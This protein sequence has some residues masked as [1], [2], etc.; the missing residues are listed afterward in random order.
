MGEVCHKQ[1]ICT[2][3]YQKRRLRVYFCNL[4]CGIFGKIACSWALIAKLSWLCLD[5]LQP[6]ICSPT[7]ETLT[8]KPFQSWTELHPRPKLDLFHSFYWHPCHIPLTFFLIIKLGCVNL[9]SF[10]IMKN[11]TLL[12]FNQNFGFSIRDKI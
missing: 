7:W 10:Q 9:A 2:H 12:R 6:P 3:S 11:I 8:V 5:F 4:E 1:Y